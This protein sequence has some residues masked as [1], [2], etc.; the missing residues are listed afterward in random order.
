MKI[1]KVTWWLKNFMRRNMK[2]GLDMRVLIR[3]KRIANKITCT[4][5]NQVVDIFITM[6]LIIR[7]QSEEVR[8][9]PLIKT[10]KKGRNHL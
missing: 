10:Q 1:V 3:L 5:L 9:D 7:R 4:D 6:L 8:R 2:K